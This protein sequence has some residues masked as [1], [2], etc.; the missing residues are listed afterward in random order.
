MDVGDTRKERHGVFHPSHLLSCS[1]R[2]ANPE[3]LFLLSLFCF[4]R[5][6]FGFLTLWIGSSPSR[7]K[8]LAPAHRIS[9]GLCGAARAQ[10]A[11]KPG[12]HSVWELGQGYSQQ[13]SV[14]RVSITGG[15][16]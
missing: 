2:S 14:G 8:R 13:K 4:N 12:Y 16:T 6:V 5:Q 10:R 9:L 1:L 15:E 11:P 3:R 7:V